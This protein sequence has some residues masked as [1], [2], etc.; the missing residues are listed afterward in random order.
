MHCFHWSGDVAR[1][2]P[3]DV[4]DRAGEWWGTH[5]VCILSPRYL[6]GLEAD[7]KERQHCT[8]GRKISCAVN[9][10]LR[11]ATCVAVEADDS[12]YHWQLCQTS[13]AV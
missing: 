1:E 2:S 6:K 12:S 13:G 7:D 8:G 4:A 11:Q 5:V 3:Y 10:N 9:S